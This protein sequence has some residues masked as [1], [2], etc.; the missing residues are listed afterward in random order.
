[1][2]PESDPGHGHSPAAW[3]AVIVMIIAFAIGTVAFFLN[4]Q[5]LVWASAGLLILERCSARFSPSWATPLVESDI[6]R[7]HT[8][9]VLDSLVAGALDDASVR[10]NVRPLAVVEADALARLPA[11]D[12]VRC[13]RRLIGSGSSL[14]LKR[15]S[16]SRGALGRHPRPGSTRSRLPKPAA[17]APS[18]C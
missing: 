5:W 2:T 13:S 9:R 15:A 18:A 1:M 17:Q 16:P 10:R 7:R 11:L 3:T 14:R 6:R 12:V 4:V 8:T